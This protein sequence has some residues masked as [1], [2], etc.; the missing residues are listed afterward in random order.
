[1]KNVQQIA[2]WIKGNAMNRIFAVLPMF[3]ALLLSGLFLFTAGCS[4]DDDDDDNDDSD[5]QPPNILRIVP[6]GGV[7]ADAVPVTIWSSDRSSEP[8]VIYYTLDG[9]DPEVLE[10]GDFSGYRLPSPAHL[11]LSESAVVTF[12]AVDAKG[13]ATD[14]KN[15]EFTIDQEAPYS[16]ASL[17]SGVYG[18]AQSV[19]IA[20]ADNL[21]AGTI[22]IYYTLD[23]GDPLPGDPLTKVGES[24]VE[25]ILVDR[26]RVLKYFAEDEAGN[27]EAVNVREYAIDPT[28]PNTLADP[29]SRTF[30]GSLTVKLMATDDRT[31]HPT[32]YYTLDGSDPEVP[33]PAD[34]DDDDTSP[35]DDDDATPADDDDDNDNNND[36]SPKFP[37]D[38]D[39]ASP[40]DDDDTSPADDDD[41]S[42][43]DDDDTS[44]TDDDDTSPIDD[45]DDNDDDNDD[46]TPPTGTLS[47]A[48]PIVLNLTETTTVKFLAV[49][50]AGNVEPIRTEVYTYDIIAPVVAADVAGGLYTEPFEVELTAYD[51]V[52]DSSNELTVYY[53]R[54]GVPPF[55]GALNTYAG[56]S[57]ISGIAVDETTTLIF[58]AEDSAGNWGDAVTAV[59]SFDT[60]GPTATA[61]PPGGSYN[62]PQTVTITALD[63]LGAA[64]T[65]YYTID[66]ST[67]VPDQAGTES[68]TSPLAIQIDASLTLTY[69]AADESD[70]CS[71]IYVDDYCIDAGAPVTQVDPVPG[72][73]P[74]PVFLT[75][76]AV[77]DCTVNPDIY[78][79]LDGTEPQIGGP[80]T[81]H[82]VSPVQH[83]PIVSA[84]TVRYFAVD[85]LGNAETPQQIDYAIDTEAP[86]VTAD[87]AG[88]PRAGSFSV[89][90]TAVDNLSTDLTIYYTTDNTIPTAAS[91]S[92][93]SPLS[94]IIDGDTLLQFAAV[95]EA[96]NW[97]AIGVELYTVDNQPPLTT[98]TPDG[99]VYAGDILVSLRAVDDVTAS[100]TI[101]FT[102]DGSAPT[103]GG[104]T[105]F[106]GASPINGIWIHDIGS[107]NLR[108]YAV[109]EV[110]NQETPRLETYTIY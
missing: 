11:T 44:P 64:L 15:A 57:P 46:T 4:C 20:A 91:P 35:A 76:T 31:A 51:N 75:L 24:P 96:G 65:V 45:D 67:P 55:P 88:G 22:W 83:L 60:T 73:F 78:Y 66:G 109:D 43:T 61:D 32:I 105:T 71:S 104:P 100:P 17:D 40:A 42:P 33:Q 54:D 21:E 63:D 99:G 10:N 95:D 72:L 82:D 79:T 23:G 52:L 87:P 29:P 94:L 98:A 108:F 110:G 18:A 59:Y 62:G 14:P 28:I 107:T 81:F 84:T 77:D 48:S 97:S 86:T 102:L 68:G 1:M 47:G 56:S 16:Q 39:D 34:D 3:A 80:T 26:D 50:E 70:N 74:A 13:N 38:D 27:R 30:N 8:V 58:F 53:S 41:T 36:A 92:A 49:D 90:L 106:S 9:S 103:P 89:T 7:Y 6:D 5:S 19:S 101:Y 93:P 85:Q 2:A 69:F 25:N 12:I 37:L